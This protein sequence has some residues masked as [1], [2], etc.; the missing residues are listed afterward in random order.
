MFEEYFGKKSSDTPINS[1]AQST[2]LHEDLP[3]TSSI[4]IEQ[5]EAPLIKTTSDEQ[6]SPISLTKDDELHREDS[7]DFDALLNQRISK[8]LRQITVG[9]SPNKYDAENIVLRNK[10]RLVAKGYRSEEGIDF[11]ESF[12]H[13]ARL[14]G[15]RMLKKSLYGLKQAPQA[16]YD[17]LSSFL[18]EHGF[19]KDADHAGCKDDYKSTSV[20]L[21]FLGGKL[22]S[23]SLKKQDCTAMSTAEAEYVSLSEH[24]EKGTME[25]YFVGIEYQLANLFSKALPK[26]RF[27]DLVHCI[28]MRS[29]VHPDE[30]CPP[31]K[32]Y[33]LM[34][35]NKKIDME[36][37]QCPP[38][39]KILTNIIKNHPL[40]FSIAASSFVPWIYMAQ[41]WHTLKEDDLK[42]RLK[43]MLDRKELSLTLDDFRT[44]FHLPQPTDNNHDRFVPQVSFY[45]MIP[46]YVNHLGFTIELKTP[47]SFKITGLLQSCQMLCKIFSKMLNNTYHWMRSTT[48]AD[49]PNKYKDKVGIKI[50]DWMIK[51]AIKQMEHYKMYAEKSTRLTPPAPVLTV[52]KADEMIS[53]DTLQKSTRLTPPAPVLMVDKVDEMISQDT[54]QVS[55]AEHKS[56]QEPEA[57]ENVALVEKHL[58]SEKIEKM[59]EG[60][61]HVV[62]DSSFL[63]NDEHNIPGN[64]LEP[65]SDKESL[66]VEFTYVVIPV[67]VY[68]EEVEED[69]IT[70]EVYELKQREKWKNV[71]ESR[72]IP[73]PTQIRSLRIHIDLVR[74]MPQKSFGTLANHIHDAM[75]ESLPVIV[76]KHV[77]EQVELQVPEQDDPHDD[78]HPQGENSAK[79]QKTSEYKAYVYGESSSR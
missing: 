37:V 7:I 3:S 49:N 47:S 56:R 21:Q 19:T 40:R 77:K 18:I 50:P 14:E 70:D 25:L 68:D 74:F 33:D 64:R 63:R 5:H 60:Q 34:Y 66:E 6:T 29:N 45:D 44:I 36:H 15:V 23:W 71:E 42:Y 78:A 55:L 12:A 75:T 30:L 22:V 17:K 32:W 61:E 53:Q 35:A 9:L 62:D 1:A 39:S 13:V 57:R 69:E 54:L 28:D 38:E 41:F 51:E 46:F 20:G 8:K 2:Q 4:N 65:R 73:S 11:E 43:F 76:D 48:F 31:N 58:A 26:E 72:I 79:W 59:V 27:E 10:A 67:N 16:W 24:V 52:D